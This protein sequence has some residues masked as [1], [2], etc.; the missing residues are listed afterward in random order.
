MKN[1]GWPHGWPLVCHVQK[2]KL[3]FLHSYW[4]VLLLGSECSEP[5]LD[6]DC[7]ACLQVGRH[8]FEFW[9]DELVEPE[10]DAHALRGVELC[11]VLLEEPRAV[12]L[13]D[14]ACYI[15]FGYFVHVLRNKSVEQK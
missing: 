5:V 9:Q 6:G 11:E 13:G 3:S 1:T 4:H 10:H 8:C 7:C 14:Y 2:L 15:V 12:I